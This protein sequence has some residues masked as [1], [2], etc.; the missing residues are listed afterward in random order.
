MNESRMQELLQNSMVVPGY[1]TQSFYNQGGA[2]Q[3]KN[4][5]KSIR[6]GGGKSR[7]TQVK[8]DYSPD[9]VIE[10]EEAKEQ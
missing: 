8:T 1:R 3:P 10:E 2:H 9:E 4:V 5:I 7:M 6:G